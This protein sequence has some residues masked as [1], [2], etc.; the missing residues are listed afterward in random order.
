VKLYNQAS[1]DALGL[2][3]GKT[4]FEY[5]LYMAEHPSGSSTQRVNQEEKQ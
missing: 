4:F 5:R 1:V 2:S 3:F